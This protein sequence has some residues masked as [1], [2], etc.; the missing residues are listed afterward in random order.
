MRECQVSLVSTLVT[1]LP[2]HVESHPKLFM[3]DRDVE[4][5]KLIR[6]YGVTVSVS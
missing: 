2:T 4:I 6:F 5:Y 1:Y 3:V